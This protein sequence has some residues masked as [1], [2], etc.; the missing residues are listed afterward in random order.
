MAANRGV[1][2]WL[3]GVRRI[4]LPD[5]YLLP[6]APHAEHPERA[7]V[8]IA[9]GIIDPAK[10]VRIALQNAASGFDDRRIYWSN[11]SN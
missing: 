11:R 1:D 8:D 9:A 7:V 10:V 4:T 5:F 3:P 6:N 2:A